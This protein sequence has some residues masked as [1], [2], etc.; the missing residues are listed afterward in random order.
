PDEYV[1]GFKEK[2]LNIIKPC[3]ELHS[4][5]LEI[6]ALGLRWPRDTFQKYHNIGKPNH[7]SVRTLHYYPVPENFTLFPGQT[8]C[9][10]HTDF[11][12]FSL[13]FQDDVGGLEVKTVDG[14]FV[15]ATPLPGAIL[16]IE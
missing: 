8:R 9:G 15:A 13:L 16:V 3:M 2:S 6:T 4:R 10:K 1:P 7:N 11:G 5:L 12:S 14:E